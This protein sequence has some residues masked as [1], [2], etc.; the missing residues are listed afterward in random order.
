LAREN[1]KTW[2]TIMNRFAKMSLAA[3]A[4]SLT[5]LSA[6]PASAA[7]IVVSLRGKTA[8][9]VSTEIQAAALKVCRAEFARVPLS[10]LTT[11][12]A[13][14]AQDTK[15]QLPASLTQ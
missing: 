9:Q 8:N 4:L 11:C 3:A 1:L 12:A 13:E 6:M 5:A 10:T 14:V 15:N 2:R 7:E